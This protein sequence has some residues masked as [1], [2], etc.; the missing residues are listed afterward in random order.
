MRVLL[1]ISAIW[2]GVVYYRRARAAV[3]YQETC[4]LIDWWEQ[5]EDDMERRW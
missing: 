4:E 2:L 3:R 5:W 1:I